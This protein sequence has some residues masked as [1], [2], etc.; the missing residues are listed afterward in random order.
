MV[1]VAVAIFIDIVIPRI[2]VPTIIE[3]LK[4]IL[5]S[6]LLAVWGRARLCGDLLSEKIDEV[7]IVAHWE[8]VMGTLERVVVL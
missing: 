2:Y 4:W 1:F 8:G 3:S 5:K 7:W 6:N